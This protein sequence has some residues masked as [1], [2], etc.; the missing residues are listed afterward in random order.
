MCVNPSMK[1]TWDKAD[2][3]RALLRGMP[4]G[5]SSRQLPL[6]RAGVLLEPAPKGMDMLAS[7]TGSSGFHSYLGFL[8]GLPAIEVVFCDPAP[9]HVWLV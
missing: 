2:K 8:A 4:I 7:G 3:G 6:W 1:E 9:G 5:P